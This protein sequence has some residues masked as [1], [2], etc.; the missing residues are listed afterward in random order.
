MYGSLAC[1]PLSHLVHDP[2]IAFA[3]Y[4]HLLP[5]RPVKA[6]LKYHIDA[7]GDAAGGASNQV[8]IM[9]DPMGA[10]TKCYDL[11]LDLWNRYRE[12]AA[13]EIFD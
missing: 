11:G 6:R 8:P 12:V 10:L 5:S 2:R 9:V 3:Y 4:S 1:A 13:I 7:A